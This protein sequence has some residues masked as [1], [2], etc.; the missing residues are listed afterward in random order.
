M[1]VHS[2]A[3]VPA[4]P[5]SSVDKNFKRYFAIAAARTTQCERSSKAAQTACFLPISRS[6]IYLYTEHRSPLSNALGVRSM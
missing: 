1:P 2:S 5:S 3:R 4:W 6:T